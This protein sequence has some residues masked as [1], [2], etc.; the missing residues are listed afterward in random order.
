V[1]IDK[2]V[3]SFEACKSLCERSRR[4]RTLGFTYTN[5]AAFAHKRCK[6]PDP[7]SAEMTT[8]MT[9]VDPSQQSTTYKMDQWQYIPDT[10]CNIGLKLG[11]PKPNITTDSQCRAACLLNSEC[12]YFGYS[13]NPSVGSEGKP[14]CIVSSPQLT[15][16]IK[17]CLPMFDY[18]TRQKALDIVS[19]LTWSCYQCPTGTYSEFPGASK[20]L[21]HEKTNK[22]QCMTGEIFI[23]PS[24]V[25][26]GRC[27][28]TNSPGLQIPQTCP[29]NNTMWR[30]YEIL[31]PTTFISHGFHGKWY[32][33]DVVND[34]PF[35]ISTYTNQRS[36][37]SCRQKCM[38]LWVAADSTD[39]C[40]GITW[41]ALTYECKT[42]KKRLANPPSK[43]AYE[44]N[45]NPSRY[46][47]LE[48]V[49]RDTTQKSCER[50]TACR[51]GFY[52]SNNANSKVFDNVCT[53]CPLGKWTLGGV[54]LTTMRSPMIP[55]SQ[56]D[57]F[58]YAARSVADCFQC[59]SGKPLQYSPNQR[60]PPYTIPDADGTLVPVS[61]ATACCP[62]T[63]EL[64]TCSTYYGGRSY[65]YPWTNKEYPNKYNKNFDICWYCRECSIGDGPSFIQSAD[66]A[67]ARDIG[68]CLPCQ[69]NTQSLGCKDSECCLPGIPCNGESGKKRSGAY[70]CSACT[71]GRYTIEPARA[72][73]CKKCTALVEDP[74]LPNFELTCAKN[75][76][77]G[78]NYGNLSA[79]TNNAK[80]TSNS[81]QYYNPENVTVLDGWQHIVAITKVSSFFRQRIASELGERVT[82]YLYRKWPTDAISTTLSGTQIML[83]C[84][85]GYGLYNGDDA[86]TNFLTNAT[87]A[88]AQAA[89]SA[90][91]TI[92]IPGTVMVISD[93]NSTTSTITDATNEPG[94]LQ[95]ITK[96]RN[97]PYKTVTNWRFPV[98]PTYDSTGEKVLCNKHSDCGNA[99]ALDSDAVVNHIC[100]NRKAFTYCG[101]PD[102]LSGQRTCQMCR[103]ARYTD[104]VISAI[105]CLVPDNKDPKI[106]RPSNAR[107][108]VDGNSNIRPER[109]GV[110]VGAAGRCPTA[111]RN[112]YCS[113]LS[114]LCTACLDG[115][116]GSTTTS[117]SDATTTTTTESATKVNTY[118][119]TY[120]EDMA[121]MYMPCNRHNRCDSDTG[122]DPY[123]CSKPATRMH[124]DMT[125]GF[126]SY[127]EN[128]VSPWIK[129]QMQQKAI[130]L[131]L[132]CPAFVKSLATLPFLGWSLCVPCMTGY[133]SQE[134]SPTCTPCPAGYFPQ[135]TTKDKQVAA[136]SVCAPCNQP[137][138]GIITFKFGKNP[139]LNNAY[140]DKGTAFSTTICMPCESDGLN[141]YRSPEG[142]CETCPVGKAST[143]GVMS[144][145]GTSP[146]DICSPGYYR[147]E[148]PATLGAGGFR[149]LS[150]PAGKFTPNTKDVNKQSLQE[151][152][153]DCPIGT[154]T[155]GKVGFIRQTTGICIKCGTG[156]FA[157]EQGTAQCKSCAEMGNEMVPK[158]DGS[159]CDACPAGKSAVF[160]TDNVS[161]GIYQENRGAA[162]NVVIRGIHISASDDGCNW[163]AAGY[164]RQGNVVNSSG[165]MACP[166]GKFA[167]SPRS[168][169]CTDCPAGRYTN[170]TGQV[171]CEACP[172]GKATGARLDVDGETLIFLKG[173]SRCHTC[174]NTFAWR[175]AAQFSG[176]DPGQTIYPSLREGSKTCCINVNT[177]LSAM[178]E[179]DSGFSGGGVALDVNYWKLQYDLKS[180]FYGT[181]TTT[182]LLFVFMIYS[183]ICA[184]FLR[185]I[186]DE[187]SLWKRHFVH[188]L[189]LFDNIEA[190]IKKDDE[191]T[192]LNQDES[193]INSEI[194]GVPVQLEV[195]RR[196][197]ARNRRMWRNK[198]VV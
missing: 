197:E 145:S 140:D 107:C 122:K 8:Q 190:T 177:G 139:N 152:C 134:G 153:Q 29:G 28:P 100:R 91:N 186:S 112:Y 166:H 17:L 95:D 49:E 133:V 118:L 156:K 101:A 38:N 72:S 10:K 120:T 32:S 27:V 154:S 16:W 39:G 93:D 26:P 183:V 162:W 178:C 34:T 155:D 161:T 191:Y 56:I 13:F 36:L 86:S 69:K 141:R 11:L 126:P 44:K 47:M 143:T 30:I 80:N 142:Q 46:H 31:K 24:P 58:E 104:I 188:E 83:G 71:P 151:R 75:V 79:L 109:D 67:G 167:N 78:Y 164:Y 87:L 138:S 70:R 54:G 184:V 189:P 117:Q 94:A 136:Y 106:K 195:K 40:R 15:P 125:A 131:C 173:N 96:L 114:G 111:D 172:V 65:F 179:E 48:F 81:P 176:L 132:P 192:A 135:A 61:Q 57:E 99:A 85:A 157:S 144:S 22:E 89:N 115:S 169:A 25:Y 62:S 116:Q 165:C 181:P 174:T 60:K 127:L 21:P 55:P 20:C 194:I 9:P 74:T 158:Q 128:R 68:I 66:S 137:N 45:I 1:E 163:C 103:S 90:S 19:N 198:F 105:D 14:E 121:S 168:A 146:C 84:P 150:C 77:P 53:R 59:G 52:I 43:A 64:G 160:R 33:A 175:K 110:V 41:D 130:G 196:F 5:G 97:N 6:I 119:T 182:I 113:D 51:P 12:P 35:L 63:K 148:D 102:P 18:T 108:A 129:A 180:P 50:K 159:G 7:N 4:C 123:S 42:Y 147:M 124:C 3:A 185:L 82:P 170:R 92:P 98:P 149:C 37:K 171:K 2:L 88:A 76:P 23:P 187:T 73:E 193:P